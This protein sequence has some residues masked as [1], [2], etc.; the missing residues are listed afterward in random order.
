MEQ[1]EEDE[2]FN[3]SNII[4]SPPDNNSV[5]QQVGEEKPQKLTLNA[6]IKLK[7]YQNENGEIAVQQEPASRIDSGLEV[8]TNL[9]SSRTHI[10]IKNNV[11]NN[12]NNNN[13]SNYLCGTKNLYIKQKKLSS[14][15]NN[16]LYYEEKEMQM[17][18]TSTIIS[19]Q[20]MQEYNNNS[21]FNKSPQYIQYE[22]RKQ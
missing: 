1:E 12:S 8:N 7:I 13:N 5:T 2:R 6:Q 10:S 3:Q 9:I 4:H 17:S 22:R 19:E 15:N 18:E 21:Y 11:I 16:I 20:D 14:I